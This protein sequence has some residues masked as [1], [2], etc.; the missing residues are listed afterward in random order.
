MSFAC[1]RELSSAPG[2]EAAVFI[3][4][5]ITALIGDNN[6]K[7]RKTRL[8][9]FPAH[10]EGIAFSSREKCVDATRVVVASGFLLLHRRL[11]GVLYIAFVYV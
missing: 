5:I 9:S 4:A 2:Y 10:L 6:K 3:V 1:D 7:K 8:L 11:C